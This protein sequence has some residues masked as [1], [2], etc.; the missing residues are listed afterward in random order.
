M[1][2][3]QLLLDTIIKGLQEKKGRDLVAVDLREVAGAIC[4]YM[5]ICEGKNP[6]QIS[7]LSDS[8]WDMVSKELKEKP[9]SV[10]GLRNAQWVGMD[11]GTIIVH[12]FMPGM[13]AFYRLENLWEDS[14]I[15]RFPDV[16]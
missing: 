8:V 9:L 7:S 6:N 15:K 3:I 16:D 13:R 12:I 10:D 5:V 4:Q 2:Q 11:Y 14:K 1:N